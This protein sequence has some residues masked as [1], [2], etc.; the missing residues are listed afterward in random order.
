MRVFLDMDGVLADFEAGFEA[1]FGFRA[2]S[3]PSPDV[4]AA[5]RS[6]PDFF[7]DLPPMADLETLWRY[8]EP[9]KPVV[10][11]G[12]PENFPAALAAKRAW[13]DRHLGAHVRVIGCLR[14]EKHR[15]GLAGD[16][17][18]DDWDRYRKKWTAMGGHWITHRS[19][20]ESIR[21]FEELCQEVRG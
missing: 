8:F 7:R 17:L 16:V 13:L 18:I 19:A 21:R 9:L 1:R 14:S 5:L 10:L 4:S 6:E 2:G 20:E 3:I 15:H 12:V 11:T